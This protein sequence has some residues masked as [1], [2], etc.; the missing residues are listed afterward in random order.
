MNIDSQCQNWG[1]FFAF[2]IQRNLD[3]IIQMDCNSSMQHR[4]ASV[5]ETICS[6]LIFKS[7]CSIKLNKMQSVQ[8]SLSTYLSTYIFRIPRVRLKRRSASNLVLCDVIQKYLLIYF[9]CSKYKSIQKC[10]TSYVELMHI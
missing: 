1:L 9:Y 2:Q 6:N 3:F 10:F 7:S 8:F 5:L 4:S